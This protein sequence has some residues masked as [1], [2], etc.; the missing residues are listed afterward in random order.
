M[1]SIPDV[2][3]DL[4]PDSTLSRRR[5][6]EALELGL[7]KT[8]E[9]GTFPSNRVWRRGSR[10]HNDVPGDDFHRSGIATSRVSCTIGDRSD[11]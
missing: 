2:T 7:L 5:K 1:R 9:I 3:R 4:V 8:D 6:V 11:V 10:L